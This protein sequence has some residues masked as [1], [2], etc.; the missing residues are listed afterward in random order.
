MV[1]TFKFCNEGCIA[2]KVGSAMRRSKKYNAHRERFDILEFR[3]VASEY[4]RLVRLSMPA[5]LGGWS[6]EPA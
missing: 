6:N 1:V 4:K 5:V 2:S 3:P